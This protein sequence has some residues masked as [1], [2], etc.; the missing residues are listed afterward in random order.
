MKSTSISGGYDHSRILCPTPGTQD[1]SVE[2]AIRRDERLIRGRELPM[3]SAPDELRAPEARFS[4]NILGPLRR[5]LCPE[6]GTQDS[7]PEL[8]IFARDS[9]WDCVRHTRNSGNEHM[10]TPAPADVERDDVADEPV[11]HM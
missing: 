4:L 5:T 11:L 9:A 10:N 8:P 7:P 6:A 1:I 3:G 2:Q